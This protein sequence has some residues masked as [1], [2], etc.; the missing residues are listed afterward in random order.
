MDSGM[1]RTTFSM[2]LL[3]LF[4]QQM[5]VASHVL[6]RPYPASN[7]AQLKDLLHRF[8]DTLAAVATAEMPAVEYE[9][10]NRESEQSQNNPG[11]DMALELAKRPVHSDVRDPTADENYNRA[12]VQ[13]SQLQDLLM[14]SRS[15][16]VSGCFGA[17]MDRIGTLS[18]LGCGPKRG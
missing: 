6:D 4:S 12:Q 7:F 11:W 14:A 2:A 17:R 8:E 3:V 5:L 18:G 9:D 10:T 15:K 1:A 13:R 16:A